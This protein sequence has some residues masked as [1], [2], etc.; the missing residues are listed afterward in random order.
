[1]ILE[2]KPKRRSSLLFS[3]KCIAAARQLEANGSVAHLENGKIDL[4]RERKNIKPLGKTSKPVTAYAKYRRLQET[5]PRAAGAY[6]R[7]N[8]DA[9]I[10]GL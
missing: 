9:I 8:K 3:A 5:D 6:W 10:N 1:M 2:R 7:A 4:F